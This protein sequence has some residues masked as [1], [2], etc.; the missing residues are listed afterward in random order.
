MKSKTATFHE[1]KWKRLSN[2]VELQRGSEGLEVNFHHVVKSDQK[3]TD[4][5]YFAFTYPY[6]YEDVCKTITKW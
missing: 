2:K 5:I 6:S 3:P 1:L 4:V